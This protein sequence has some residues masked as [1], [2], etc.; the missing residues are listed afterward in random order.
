MVVIEGDLRGG[1]N[2]NRAKHR[3][4]CT[5]GSMIA[6]AHRM[7]GDRIR[8]I[9]EHARR[10]NRQC[11]A[12]RTKPAL[13]GGTKDR[14]GNDVA[15]DVGFVGMQRECGK[16]PPWFGANDEITFGSP[17]LKPN[18]VCRDRTRDQEKQSERCKEQRNDDRRSMT[19]T[20]ANARRR[21][22]AIFDFIPINGR[23]CPIVVAIAYEQDPTTGDVPRRVPDR[24][25]LQNQRPIANFALIHRANR[26]ET[27][28][29]RDG[30][31]CIWSSRTRCTGG[32][33][34]STDSDGRMILRK[35][36]ICSH[37][38]CLVVGVTHSR[39]N[40]GTTL[41]P[42]NMLS[43]LVRRTYAWHGMYVSSAITNGIR[44]SV[45]SVYVPAQSSP[46]EKR[47]VFAYTVRIGNEGTQVAQLRSRH[48][49]ITDAKG[50]VEEV[51]GPGVVGKQ[52]TL[53]PGEHFEYTSGC[54]LETPR[55]TMH[56]TYQMHRPDGEQF[57]AEIAP[58][59]L[60]MP[61]NL[62]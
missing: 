40:V 3:C 7:M 6:I 52:P 46:T 34:K 37:G 30:R 53:R 11:C 4:R 8:H 45:T 29:W 51:K 5:N 9:S 54:V 32:S 26:S 27:R 43:A 57:D 21:P 14:P 13:H 56:G 60:S 39:A 44:V 17:A 20:L 16:S 24:H 59:A 1:Q 61:F 47:Y 19:R 55:G 35:S 38:T 33:R 50:K 41:R 48:W 28:E 58:F 42:V 31:T 15:E 62:N 23:G 49:I 25:G 22:I 18:G 12:S 2:A 10:E 36:T